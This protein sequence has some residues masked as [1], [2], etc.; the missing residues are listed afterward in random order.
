MT[1]S[2]TSHAPRPAT[3][4]LQSRP[5]AALAPFVD[6]FSSRQSSLGARQIY[7]P[8]P[9]RTDCFLEFYF[10]DRYHV[11][12]IAS[13]AVHL[14]PRSVLV[15]PHS[16]RREDILLTG[17]L[18][19]FSIRFTPIGFRT[20]FGVPA[21]AIANAAEPAALV[22]GPQIARLEDRLAAAEPAAR[23]A[24]AENFLLEILHL[25][26]IASTLAPIAAIA[27]TLKARH[28]DVN[29]TALAAAHEIT[30]RQLQ[31]GF[32]EHVGLSPKL[33]ARLAR[34]NRALS[35]SRRP[36]APDWSALAAAT[37]YFDHSHMLRDFRDLIG[38][39]PVEFAAL[40]RRAVSLPLTC[41]DRPDVAFVLSPHPTAHLSSPS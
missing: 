39:T 29:L 12:D 5:C 10:A 14:A 40:H 18:D 41:E 22:L 11:I 15:G 35:L 27:R 30:P 13:R 38:Q 8:L 32:Q 21:H 28:G 31:R 6:E 19:V 37:G 9:A 16:R 20:L 25:T 3:V 17:H 23:A 26:G 2:E 1:Q 7:N 33:F 36:G 24:V 4:S 34:L